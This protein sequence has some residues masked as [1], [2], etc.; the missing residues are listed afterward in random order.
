MKN[1]I[2]DVSTTSVFAISFVFLLLAILVRKNNKSLSVILS[3]AT[4][5]L[6]INFIV[7]RPFIYETYMIPSKSMEKTI[8]EGDLVGCKKV[9]YNPKDG[10]VVIFKLQS[11]DNKKVSTVDLL[12]GRDDN[13]EVLIKR[14][15]AKENDNVNIINGHV[16]RNNERLNEPYVSNIVQD[17]YSFI[18]PKNSYFVMGDNR[19]NSEDSRDFGFI[20]KN[21]IV[22]KAEKIL[23]PINRIKKL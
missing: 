7:I 18:V 9:F 13:K 8:L 3:I 22:G 4:M 5:F 20:T 17:N 6:L 15:I 19:A 16:Y 21:E 1:G 14:I 2:I 10:D 23:F 11:G 12:L